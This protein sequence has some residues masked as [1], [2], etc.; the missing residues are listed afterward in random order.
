M[1]SRYFFGCIGSVFAG[2]RAGGVLFLVSAKDVKVDGYLLG[3]CDPVDSKEMQSVLPG[4]KGW[5]N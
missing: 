5:K 2:F 4:I 3:L 1:G